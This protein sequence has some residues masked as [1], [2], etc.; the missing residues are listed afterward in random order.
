MPTFIVPCGPGGD[1]AECDVASDLPYSLKDDADYVADTA[2][3]RIPAPDLATAT[4][5]VDKIIGYETSPPALAGSGFYGHLSV[6]SFFEPTFLCELNPGESP[7]A[8]CDAGGNASWVFHPEITQD[9]RTFTKIS[10]RVPK[11]DASR[12]LRRR[13][14]LFGAG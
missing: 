7:P 14:A 13:P 9:A 6:T 4:A 10:E 12:R 1:P 5:V 8:N 2:L 3:G 11:R